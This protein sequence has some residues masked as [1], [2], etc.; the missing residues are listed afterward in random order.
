[1]VKEEKKLNQTFYRTNQNYQVLSIIS[2]KMLMEAKYK[3]GHEN[4]K[5]ETC[6]IKYIDL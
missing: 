1:M 4:E 5:R 2:L 3:Y 6:E